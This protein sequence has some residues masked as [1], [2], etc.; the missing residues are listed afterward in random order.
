M[1]EKL[2]KTFYELHRKLVK[3]II[4]FCKENDTEF[5][6]IHLDVDGLIESIKS[7][8][9]SPAT[10]S[11]LVAYKDSRTVSDVDRCVDP[12]LVSC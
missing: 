10:D 1:E 4:N 11:T 2:N 6:E 8:E 5:D 7:G 9:W 3:E 12:F